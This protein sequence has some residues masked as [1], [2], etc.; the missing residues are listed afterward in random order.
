M[1]S[2]WKKGQTPV[3]ATDTGSPR[4]LPEVDRLSQL[5]ASR[6]AELLE[7]RRTLADVQHERDAAHAMIERFAAALRSVMLGDLSVQL[8]SDGL[9]DRRVVD[10]FNAMTREV[11]RALQRIRNTAGPLLDAADGGQAAS[12]ELQALLDGHAEGLRRVGD[13]I[14]TLTSLARAFPNDIAQADRSIRGFASSARELRG[15]M[16]EI[17]QS[18]SHAEEMARRTTT[19]IDRLETNAQ[20]IA[21]ICQL[22]VEAADRT[23]LLALNASIQA[24]LAG[25]AGR[26]F[27]AVAEEIERLAQRSTD[28]AKQISTLMRSFQTEAGYA[29]RE[30]AECLAGIVG[31]QHHA[32]STRR[33]WTEG[34]DVSETVVSTLSRLATLHAEQAEMAQALCATVADARREAATG[35]GLADS[36][37]GAN[38][39]V[40]QRLRDLSAW[41]D[42]FELAR[43]IGEAATTVSIVA[44]PI[45]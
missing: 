3:T 39:A 27:A 5:L 25:E 20:D 35:R 45:E 16:D 40:V 33:L 11:T 19:R 30:V 8:S 41:A 14:D 22:I 28:A 31:G 4:A 34:R 18:I 9:S 1:S 42:Q 2:R 32:E 15:G 29:E 10:A 6:D 12:H 26:A 44:D 13:R 21:D 23:G 17:F 24:A 7:I 36:V 43:P 37:D 38:R